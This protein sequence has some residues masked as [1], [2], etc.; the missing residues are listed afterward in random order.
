M[1][2]SPL[3]FQVPQKLPISAAASCT[4][5]LQCSCCER[6]KQTGF[7]S[8]AT[9]IPTQLTGNSA[10]RS[11]AAAS[12]E[13]TFQTHSRRCDSDGCSRQRALPA[14]KSPAD[15]RQPRSP[16]LPN[17]SSNSHCGERTELKPTAAAGSDPPGAPRA[18]YSSVLLPPLPQPSAVPAMR[19]APSRTAS[20]RPQSKTSAF[21]RE[22]AL[23]SDGI[24]LV[25]GQRKGKSCLSS[26]VSF[27][28][29]QAAA[30]TPGP[31]IRQ[32]SRT[33][34]GLLSSPAGRSPA[35]SSGLCLTSQCLGAPLTEPRALPEPPLPH[36]AR[37]SSPRRPQSL[38]RRHRGADAP[39]PA[40]PLTSARPAA[41]SAAPTTPGSPRGAR[42]QLP[43]AP[44]G[45]RR[46]R[47]RFQDGAAP[48]GVQRALPPHLHFRPHRRAGRRAVRARLRSGR[49]RH[50]RAPQRGGKERSGCCRGRGRWERP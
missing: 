38:S 20:H 34:R 11:P 22:A 5:P 7:R 13:S 12:P 21:Q 48:A 39:R 30:R 40:G 37:L 29:F 3:K 27:E 36:T 28:R 35:Q 44:A 4:A 10:C 25:A 2:H 26:A 17:F 8:G 41:F 1:C 50:L 45:R 16:K 42:L 24:A 14:D 6:G 23:L 47:R 32:K 15:F 49:R 31:P 46:R 19:A 18:D 9:Q 43:A 33:R